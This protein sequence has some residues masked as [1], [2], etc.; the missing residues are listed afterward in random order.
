MLPQ[1]MCW[2]IANLFDKFYRWGLCWCL[3]WA[4]SCKD[5]SKSLNNNIRSSLLLLY[6][7]QM[8][9]E[10]CCYCVAAV[11]VS[12]RH[13]GCFDLK[14]SKKCNNCFHAYISNLYLSFENFPLHWVNFF[15][16]I[17]LFISLIIERTLVGG[18]WMQLL[19]FNF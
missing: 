18:C 19:T 7:S 8:Y 3:C 4:Y 5:W 2:P 16:F 13:V 1:R 12:Y 9:V 14:S 6:V 15:F 10:S 17:S 11:Y